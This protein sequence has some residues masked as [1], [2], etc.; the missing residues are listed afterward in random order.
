MAS[1]SIGRIR[2]YGR[3]WSTPQK[4]IHDIECW[5][6]TNIKERFCGLVKPTLTSEFFRHFVGHVVD[7]FDFQGTIQLQVTAEPDFFDIGESGC[8]QVA[9]E[10]SVEEGPAVRVEG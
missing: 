10:L 2:R 8:F 5:F 6:G 4:L 7:P 3:I 1:P 9:N